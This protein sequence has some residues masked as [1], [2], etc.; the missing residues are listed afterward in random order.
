[1]E[2]FQSVSVA[3]TE[4][5]QYINGIEATNQQQEGKVSTAEAKMRE[6]IK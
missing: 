1:M 4:R 6:N 5:S 3:S 2:H